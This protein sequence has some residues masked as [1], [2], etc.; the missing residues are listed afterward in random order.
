[1]FMALER[2]VAAELAVLPALTSF[3]DSS[4]AVEPAEFRTFTA[5]ALRRFGGLVA[6]MWAPAVEPGGVDDFLAAAARDGVPL[7]GVF[8]RDPAGLRVPSSSTATVF[9][10]LFAEPHAL[11][12]GDVGLDLASQPQTRDLLAAAV[13]SGTLQT[14]QPLRLDPELTD[15]DQL[16]AIA[17]VYS[18]NGH[19]TLRGGVLGLFDIHKLAKAALAADPHVSMTEGGVDLYIYADDGPADRLPLHIHPAPG[20]SPPDKLPLDL[21]LTNLHAVHRLDVTGTSLLTVARPR[22]LRPSAAPGLFSWTV[23]LSG[24]ALTSAL[25]AVFQALTGRNRL[26]A[27]LVDTRTAELARANLAIAERERHLQAIVDT[28]LDGILTIDHTGQILTANPAV[29]RLFGYSPEELIGQH[30][31]ILMPD[32]AAVVHSKGF[33][34]HMQG[35]RARIVGS[36]SEVQGRRKNGSLFDAELSI[37]ELRGAGPPNFLGVV[38]DISQRK[39]VDKLKD[40][41]ISTVSH[42]L[43]TPLTSILGSLEL[44]RDGI[45]GPLPEGADRMVTL[46]Y[47]SGERL[48]RLINDILDLE[49][50]GTG[51]MELHKTEFE[52]GQLLSQVCSSLQG[53]AGVRDVRLE[54]EPVAEPMHVHADR[55]RLVQVLTNLVGNAVRFSPAG[56]RVRLGVERV[57]TATVFRVGDEGPGIPEEFRPRL[58]APFSQADA[59]DTRRLG[60]TGLGLSIAKAIIEEHGGQIWYNT[61]EGNGTTFFFSVPGLDGT[62]PGTRP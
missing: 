50:L 27:E 20:L 35:N 59:G 40:R 11:R 7:D 56:G 21:V 5:D 42:E 12:A 13:Q 45:V 25:G 37:G 53:L 38:R 22:V 29:G 15:S 3:Y 32:H 46:A 62:A 39:E 57:G 30:V 60:G 48:V 16:V 2:E 19:R 43:R 33:A 8:T 47:D 6:L 17:P 41:F 44:L 49:R 58:F 28:T 24:L 54:I 26:I 23:L 55:D 9:P 34:Q 61:E 18:H 1:M 36:T 52:A 10:V 14:S 4:Q 51:R 31:T